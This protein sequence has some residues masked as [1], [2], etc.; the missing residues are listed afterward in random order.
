MNSLRKW[1]GKVSSRAK[2]LVKKWKQ[3]IP[4]DTQQKHAAE[5]GSRLL[6]TLESR[7]SGLESGQV[8][9]MRLEYGDLAAQCLR[10][11]GRL[12]EG[13]LRVT[14][15]EGRSRVSAGEGRS[16]VTAG[17]GRLR[18]SA[19]EGRLKVSAGEGRSRVAAICIDSGED[20]ECSVIEITPEKNHHRIK[21][22]KRKKTS[23]PQLKD[24]FARALEVPVELGRVSSRLGRQEMHPLS[25]DMRSERSPVAMVT[26]GSHH[27]EGNSVS[28]RRNDVSAVSVPASSATVEPQQEVGIGQ[29]KRSRT[30]VYSGK[31]AQTGPQGQSPLLI[32]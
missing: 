27:S 12:E 30:Q 13:R 8:E 3:L 7:G 5:I 17:E 2:S 6:S 10:E 18:V 4:E 31:R 11:E 24:E 15:G 21:D 19:G 14:A 1:G 25:R 32:L 16:R 28:Q 29:T 23:E 20:S 26:P 22:K 9:A